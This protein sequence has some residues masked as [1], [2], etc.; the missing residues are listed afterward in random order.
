VTTGQE[1]ASAVAAELAGGYRTD[2]SDDAAAPVQRGP[3]PVQV[4]DVREGDAGVDAT[5]VQAQAGDGELPPGP[6]HE[7]VREIPARS[8]RTSRSRAAA[9][10]PLHSPSSRWT[11][12]ATSWVPVSTGTVTGCDMRK[13]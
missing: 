3:V 1:M 8:A 9:P 11:S 10:H 2:F 13:R 7:R 4:G 12:V 6:E 5:G